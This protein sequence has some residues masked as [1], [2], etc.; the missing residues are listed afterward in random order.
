MKK[1]NPR[2]IL[3]N[4]LCKDEAN[5]NVEMGERLK[6]C[7]GGIKTENA[8]VRRWDILSLRNE[9]KTNETVFPST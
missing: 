7:E 8:E 9:T 2:S 6:K 4:L 5:A 3:H 1:E